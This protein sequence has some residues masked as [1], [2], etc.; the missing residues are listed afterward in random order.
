MKKKKNKQPHS[1]KW[2]VKIVEHTVHSREQNICILLLLLLS[3]GV[4]A[5]VGLRCI[6]AL[7]SRQTAGVTHELELFIGLTAVILLIIFAYL[8][9]SKRYITGVVRQ[10]IFYSSKCGSPLW[11]KWINEVPALL[12]KNKN[13]EYVYV[14]LDIKKL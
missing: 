5:P 7:S 3:G 1:E 4:L 10:Q 8:L 13:V 14:Y 6:R 2:A 9:A 11:P 12:A